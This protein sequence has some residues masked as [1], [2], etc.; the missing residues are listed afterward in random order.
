M[1]DTLRNLF[2]RLT[3][4]AYPPLAVLFELL[5]IGISVNWCAGVLQGTRG[6]RLLRGLLIVVVV[7]TL[8]LRLVSGNSDWTRLELL[9]RYFLTGLAFIAL[10]AFQPELRRA[11]IRAGEV[12]FLRRGAPSSRVVAALVES[13][14]YLSRHRFGA[15]IAIQRDVGL[16]NWAENGTLLGADVSANLLNTIFFPN[17]A[18]HDLGVIIDGERVLAANC[19]FPQAESGEIDSSLGSRHRA[20]VG[21]SQESDALVLVVSEE[22]GTISLADGGKLLRFLSIDDLQQE[23]NQ[24]L[25]RRH[26]SGG[27]RAGSL[28]LRRVGARLL[29]VAPMTLVIW[30]LA[31]QASLTEAGNIDIKLNI[32]HEPTLQVDLASPHDRSPGLFTTRLQGPVRAIDA[33][34]SATRNAPLTLDWRLGESY[35]NPGRYSPPV[36]VLLDR[37]PEL[38]RRGV[39]VL[40]AIPPNVEFSVDEI[41]SVAMP[42]RIEAGSVRVGEQRV[43][44]AEVQ[45]YLRR[46]DLEQTPADQRFVSARLGE[47]LARSQP[48]ER[49]DFGN[50]ILDKRVGGVTALRLEP[51]GVNVSL[52]VVGQ[53]EK[54][55][56]AGLSVQVLASPE[57]LKRYSVVQVDGNEWLIDIEVEGEKARVE[58]LRPQ[59]V[60][61]FLRVTSDQAAK[62]T[63]T[64]NVTLVLPEGVALVGRPPQ[65]QFRLAP[66]EDAKP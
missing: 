26:N 4:E 47:R 16:R 10:V 62:G 42:V 36:A 21:L 1:I 44:P 37:Q 50:V 64:E 25:S 9:Y 63:S 39:R 14:Q 60:S 28:N 46:A 15:L 5:L 58:S 49:M 2:D 33:L 7:V 35:E 65:V 8:M 17:S 30:F 40:G 55:R 23:L 51:D 19:Q 27:V 48:G 31:D 6:T 3:S 59:D 66:R 22:T 29:V 20:A 34:R 53:R 45:V 12:S 38:L 43:E 24:R 52:R 54:R 56:L 41:V 18:L 57:L 11:L 61:A 13:A 32:I